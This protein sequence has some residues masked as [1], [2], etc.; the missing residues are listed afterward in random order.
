MLIKVEIIWALKVEG[1]GF[2]S[3]IFFISACWPLLS[4]YRK[5]NI[6]LAIMSL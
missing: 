6:N 2:E 1:G 3:G 4:G 5:H